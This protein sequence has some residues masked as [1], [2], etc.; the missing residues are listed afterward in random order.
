MD[1]D[2]IREKANFYYSKKT[3][4]HIEKQGKDWFNGIIL[5]V[6]DKHL[7]LLDRVVKEVFITFDEIVKL[8]PY[9]ERRLE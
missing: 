1:T 4:V 8:E 3:I 6:S 9:H 5:E 2:T 7:I